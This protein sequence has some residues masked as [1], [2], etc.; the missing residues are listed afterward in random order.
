MNSD[1]EELRAAFE[2]IAQVESDDYMCAS[3]D[4]ELRSWYHR[5]KSMYAGGSEA[6]ERIAR[7]IALERF[8]GLDDAVR[9]DLGTIDRDDSCRIVDG[10]VPTGLYS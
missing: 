5:L 8:L 6:D 9:W 7:V 2:L 3:G 1:A 4:Q 10:I